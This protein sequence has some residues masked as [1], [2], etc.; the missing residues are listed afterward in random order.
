MIAMNL[1]RMRQSKWTK[2]MVKYSKV[3][4]KQLLLP[5]QDL[6]NIFLYFLPEK[7]YRLDCSWNYRTNHCLYRQQ[8]GS[9]VC[10][11]AERHGARILHGSC[12]AFIR[13][14]PFHPVYEAFRKVGCCCCY[15][16]RILLCVCG[17]ARKLTSL[18]VTL[19]QTL[20]EMEGNMKRAG[21]QCS[22]VTS[23]YFKRLA[24]TVADLERPDKGDP[25]ETTTKPVTYDVLAAHGAGAG[26]PSCSKH[27][28]TL[29]AR[30]EGT[31]R[32]GG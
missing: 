27:P 12:R 8:D 5:D 17:T 30:I 9:C 23:P 32:S 22:Q 4:G 29:A 31:G 24:K 2:H 7:L 16:Y 1:T 3:F 6:V 10:A 18:E 26:T 20:S 13:D 21:S 25:A 11:A 19:T 15:C 14:E 28:S